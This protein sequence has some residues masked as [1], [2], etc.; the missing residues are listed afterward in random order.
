M[1]KLTFNIGPALYESRWTRTGKW[2]KLKILPK[3][4]LEF[5]ESLVNGR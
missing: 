4:F 5:P 3:I 1:P 2:P